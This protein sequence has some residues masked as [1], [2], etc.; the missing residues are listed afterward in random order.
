MQKNLIIRIAI[1]QYRPHT[2]LKNVRALKRIE[3]DFMV[4]YRLK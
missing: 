2:T 4:I 1:V 3:I